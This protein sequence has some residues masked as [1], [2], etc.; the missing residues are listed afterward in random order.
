MLNS[1]THPD[2]DANTSNTIDIQKNKKA[3][4]AINSL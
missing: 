1:S 3:N 2:E 4:R